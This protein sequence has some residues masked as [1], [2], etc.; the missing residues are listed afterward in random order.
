MDDSHPAIR[1]L[2]IDYGSAAIGVAISNLDNSVATGLTTI[3]KKENEIRDSLNKLKGIIR[4][5]KISH[6]VLGL[7]KLSGG[8]EGKRAEITRAFGAK[9]ERY[10]KKITVL[11]W[12]E[13]F[14]TKAVSRVISKT[15]Y[16]DE[17]SAVYI[18]QGFLDN[19]MKGNNMTDNNE[20]NKNEQVLLIDEDGD[21]MPFTILSSKVKDGVTYILGMDAEDEGIAFFKCLDA[22][23][24][25][26]NETADEDD[27][28]NLELVDEEHEDLDLVFELFAEDFETLGIEL[29][30]EEE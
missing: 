3:H 22:K 23:I 9:C 7:P 1:Y 14:S 24:D 4:E 6:I 20:V 16:I 25:L 26:E 8:D 29:E 12:D 13:R 19:N 21:E 30:D 18:L 10:I 27:D 2:G 15:D 11:Y 5:H 17:M 28:L